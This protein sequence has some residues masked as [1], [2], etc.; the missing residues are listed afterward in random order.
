MTSIR[1]D[2]YAL[3]VKQLKGTEPVQTLDLSSKGLGSVSGIVIAKL[4]EFNTALTNLDLSSNQLCGRD[5]LGAG[6]YDAS[7]ITAIAEA[8]RVNT[9]LTDL[10]LGGNHIGAE[11]A[12]AIAEMLKFNTA[13]NKLNMQYNNMRD[14]G[15]QEL[16]DSVKGREGFELLV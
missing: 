4:I 6:K 8:L 2:G 5:R 13:L 15:K 14:E 7:G 9:A 10:S 1:L 11:G 16:R 12:N 3:P